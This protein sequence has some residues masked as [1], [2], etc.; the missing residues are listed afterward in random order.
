MQ[1]QN[2]H[3]VCRLPPVDAPLRRYPYAN[4]VYDALDM[5]SQLPFRAGVSKT[6]VLVQCSGCSLELDQPWMLRQL[7]DRDVTLHVLQPKAVQMRGATAQR[8]KGKVFGTDANGVFTARN[9]KS[10]V[11]SGGLLKEVC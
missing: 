10:I 1:S 2:P 7:V 3:C 6:V 5:A 4:E 11:P 9:V 8:S